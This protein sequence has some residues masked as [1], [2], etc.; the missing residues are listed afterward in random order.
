MALYDPD[1]L[2]A[3]IASFITLVGNFFAILFG[4]YDT[5]AF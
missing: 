3:S 1:P 2:L 5:D 4:T